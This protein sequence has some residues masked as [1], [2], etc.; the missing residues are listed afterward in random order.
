MTLEDE[1]IAHLARLA[2]EYILLSAESGGFYA[3]EPVLT[4]V[5]DTQKV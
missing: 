1:I 3:A 5:D 4:L 2:R